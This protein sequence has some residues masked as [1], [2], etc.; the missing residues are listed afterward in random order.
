MKSRVVL[1]SV[2]LSAMSSLTLA[3]PTSQ[4]SLLGDVFRSPAYG[5][6]L[7]P[8]IRC[9]RVNSDVA[10]QI[11]EFDDP[12][13]GWV[14]RVTQLSMP[15]ATP[16]TTYS[17]Q[18][19]QPHDGLL[20]Q[21][22]GQLRDQHG[23]EIVTSDVIHGGFDGK[24]PIGMLVH[25]RTENLKPRLIQ[26]ALV[27]ASD[28]LY[29]VVELNTPGRPDAAVAG[30]N[31]DERAAANAF[32]GVIDS[33][34]LL[35]RRA[36]AADQDDRLVRTRGLFANWMPSYLQSRLASQ[37]YFRLVRDG[38]DIGY[39]YEIDEY[40]AGAGKIADMPVIRISVRSATFPDA[41][42]RVEAQSRLTATID[43]NHENWMSLASITGSDKEGKPIQSN[44]SEI[45]S[46]DQ[47]VRM[48]PEAGLVNAQTAPPT[49]GAVGGAAALP[50]GKAP[51]MLQPR[52]KMVPSWELTVLRRSGAT[53]QMN[54]VSPPFQQ[55]VSPWYLPQAMNYLLPRL[56]PFREAKTFL[57]ATYLA[58]GDHGRPAVMLRYVDV[59]L[60]REVTLG[61][62]IVM[63]VPVSDR[64]GL[65]GP[66]TT[67]YLDPTT[68]AYL[69]S[70]S[71]TVSPDGRKETNEILPTDAVRLRKIFPNCVL[72]PP[73]KIV[74]NTPKNP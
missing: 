5:I 66:L 45:G 57:F 44:I 14:L 40:D 8:P 13:G 48:V 68:G 18:F 47:K 3:A 60:P 42:T 61:G 10:G 65:Q 26:D 71:E 41:K 54:N 21:T 2:F 23:E 39:T 33:V 58:D 36:I 50:G 69:G 17:D 59:L 35:D 62:R 31:A 19:N 55:Q 6:A 51:D 53:A 24:L 27:E 16:L 38:K 32:N 56:L 43:R 30:E 1:L 25:R 70:V 37:Q 73:D 34:E 12:D 7:R 74:D 4:P 72:T 29:Y 46:S 20:Q 49:A 63:A 67:H 11:V 9:G 52:L 28:R 64:I 22:V 15:H